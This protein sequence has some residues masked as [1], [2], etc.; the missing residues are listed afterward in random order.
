MECSE[1]ATY[2]LKN[3]L[4][5]IKTKKGIGYHAQW[6]GLPNGKGSSGHTWSNKPRSMSGASYILVMVNQFTKWAQLAALPA[7][8]AELTA[9][10]FLKHSIH[11]G[12]LLRSMLTRVEISHL[13]YFRLFVDLWRS[14][15]Q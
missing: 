2:M 10:A 4:S 6:K 13:T 7:Q 1:I 5:A 11:L 12:A 15:K 3:V 8:N 9:K 14:Q